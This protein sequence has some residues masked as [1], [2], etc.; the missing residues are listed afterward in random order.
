M[1][2]RTGYEYVTVS[3]IELGDGTPTFSGGKTYVNIYINVK[4]RNPLCRA[5]NRGK[6]RRK[7]QDQGFIHI[8]F[9][10]PNLAMINPLL[11]LNYKHKL[12]LPEI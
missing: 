6:N 4:I 12:R 5:A 7:R 11:E 8:H 2:S 1:T 10:N 9:S 3:Q